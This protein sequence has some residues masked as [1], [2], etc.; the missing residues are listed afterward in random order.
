P[1]GPAV[2]FDPDGAAVDE[3]DAP[4]RIPDQAPE[5]APVPDSDGA[6]AIDGFEKAATQPV[7]LLAQAAEPADADVAAPEDEPFGPPGATPGPQEPVEIVIVVRFL[8]DVNDEQLQAMLKYEKPAERKEHNGRAWFQAPLKPAERLPQPVFDDEGQ[9]VL[10]NG[11]QKFEVVK[12]PLRPA[13][14]S[15][16]RV[17]AR[18]VVFGKEEFIPKLLD[19]KP[20]A[21][22]LRK[23]LAGVQV[24]NGLVIAGHVGGH[25]KTADAF[26]EQFRKQAEFAPPPVQMAVPFAETLDGA[27]LGADLSAPTTLHVTFEMRDADAA[28][29]LAETGDQGV[30]QIQAMFG[31]MRKGLEENP[32]GVPF[33]QGAEVK[34]ALDMASRLL[35]GLSVKR[36]GDTRVV[37]E[38][39]RPA[40][41]D[42]F[43]KAKAPAAILA[44]RAETRKQMRVVNLKQIGIALHAHHGIY[45]KF[46]AAAPRYD[47]KEP[48]Q[49]SW[50]VHVLEQLDERGLF[51]E[52]DFEQ[53]WD[54]EANKSFL[55]RMPAIYGDPTKPD[56][57]EE[58]KTRI[59]LVTGRNTAWDGNL[60]VAATI[61]WGPRLGD[62]V[63]GASNT[64]MLVELPAEKAVP[65]TQPADFVFDR[66]D[67]LKNL[68][69]IPPEGLL[70][71][72]VDG[73]VWRIPADIDPVKFWALCTNFGG[74][75]VGV[76]G[77]L[78]AP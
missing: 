41:L 65:W 75:V 17:D 69:P 51:K 6:A 1:V 32:D 31:E 8:E 73:R 55:A 52:Y 11:G 54:S 16:F 57:N 74:E 48:G 58:G 47:E 23:L 64:I 44:M 76:D 29:Q 39:K 26:R 40:G 38:L 53:P 12:G 62:F 70:C 36:D 2:P 14:P 4:A 5:A 61:G 30:K 46:P 19:N 63:D 3:F 20:A 18:T 10:E 7:A 25:E 67:P 13:G 60:P 77:V 35:D 22:P 34:E 56:E 43:V 9:P 71:V 72:T 21:T 24:G 50:R 66:D 45:G 33:L 27:L 49:T 28:K 15:Y 42:E 59:A 37:G 68:R 78:V